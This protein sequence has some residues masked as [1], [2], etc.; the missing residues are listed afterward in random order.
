MQPARFHSAA[1]FTLIG[2][3][4]SV[5]VAA[6]LTML[7]VS[8]VGSASA[9]V[10]ARVAE[11]RL[12]T[13][14]E[15]ARALAITGDA[16]IILCPSRDGQRC[17]TDDHW[18]HGWIAF[19]DRIE[20]GERDDGEP[21]LLREGTLGTGVHLVSTRGRTRLRFQSVFG[22]NGGSNVTFTLCDPRGPRAAA[23]WVLSNNGHLHAD[24]PK[25]AN[26]ASA[27]SG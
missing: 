7:L 5:A 18:E 12:V 20:N 16:D 4:V 3:I 25:A 21:T 2:L 27:C 26:V 9:K 24:T 14:L 15:R 10:S 1:G 8:T 19:A 6:I 13:A 11:A 23:A 17:A 22:S